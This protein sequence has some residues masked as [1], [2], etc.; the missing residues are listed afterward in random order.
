MLSLRAICTFVDGEVK[1]LKREN[2]VQSGHLLSL[3]KTFETSL[4]FTHVESKDS[5]QYERQNL[6][7]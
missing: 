4:S 2:A 7:S 5:S 3:K 6:Y 1:L